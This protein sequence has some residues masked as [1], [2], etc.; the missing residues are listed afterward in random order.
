MFTIKKKKYSFDLNSN[1]LRLVQEFFVQPQR[2]CALSVLFK[3]AV[4]S[5]TLLVAGAVHAGSAKSDIVDTA[6]AAGSFNTLVTAVKAAELVDTL[7]GAGPFTVFAPNDAAFAKVPADTLKGLLADKA[8]LAKVLTY[9]VVPGKVMAADVVHSFN[10]LMSKQ[11]SPQ[12]KTIFG[13]IKAVRALAERLVKF[14]FASSNGEPSPR[15][16]VE[17]NMRRAS[18]TLVSTMAHVPGSEI[19]STSSE[20]SFRLLVL[21]HPLKVDAGARRCR[22]A[23]TGLF[24]LRSW[25]CRP[26][27]PFRRDHPCGLGRSL[28]WRISR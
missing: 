15:A 26:P 21:E 2:K 17:R 18:W 14:E 7:K 20:T 8:A 6:V 24:I 1:P 19:S 10:T 11:A 25:V 22:A 13:D 28:G 3:S 27:L 12:F 9:H 23:N 16:K 4:I 5:A